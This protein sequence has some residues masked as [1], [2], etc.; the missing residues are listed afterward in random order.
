MNKGTGAG[1]SNTNYFGK[2]FEEKT[3]NEKRLLECGFIKEKLT[4]KKN[5]YYLSKTDEEKKIIYVC[6]NK[7]R[8]YMEIK[9]KK[10]SYRCPDEAYI[11]EYNDGKT[12]IKILEKK[13][14]NKEGSTETKLWTG[15][16]LKR[17]YELVFGENFKIVYGFCLNNFLQNKIQS[18]EN[19][20]TILNKILNENNIEILFGDET[21]Y[22]ESLDNWI[23][24]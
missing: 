22:F 18:S 12:V 23:G 19:K 17:E 3:D 14:Q 24:I 4:K 5:D 6:Q 7:F 9:Y 11:L 8:K 13:V 15:P 1:G 21:N 20:Y 10:K 2:K 16:S